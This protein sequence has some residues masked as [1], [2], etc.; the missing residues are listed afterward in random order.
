[1]CY[2]M[3]C[4]YEMP[5]GECSI[6]GNCEIPD[7]AECERGVEDGNEHISVNQCNHE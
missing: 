5:S 6:P 3:G 1:M 2:G 7:D 4:H